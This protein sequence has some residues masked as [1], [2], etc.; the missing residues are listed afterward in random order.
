MCTTSFTLADL[1]D[2]QEAVIV[3]VDAH[4]TQRERFYD[5]GLVPGSRVK[6]LFSSPA[7]SPVAYEVIGTVLALRKK[8]AEKIQVTIL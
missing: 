8:D 1:T 6:K 2:Q 3:S 5:L 4:E 7:G